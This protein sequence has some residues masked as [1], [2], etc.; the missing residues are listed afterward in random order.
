MQCSISV[1]LMHMVLLRLSQPVKKMV[2]C[3][4]YLEH[5]CVKV[6]GMCQIVEDFSIDNIVSAVC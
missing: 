6:L 2:T 4:D 1:G 5:V 3:L